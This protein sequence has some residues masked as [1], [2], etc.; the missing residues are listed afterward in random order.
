MILS[1]YKQE[2]DITSALILMAPAVVN[3]YNA[4]V[5]VLL[6][7]TTLTSVPAVRVAIKFQELS[8]KA[9]HQQLQLI[10]H[11]EVELEQ[12]VSSMMMIQSLK[13]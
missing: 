6:V 12:I 9:P 7:K 10:L 13:N 1:A 4:Q 3:S 11:S 2:L 8:V 5:H